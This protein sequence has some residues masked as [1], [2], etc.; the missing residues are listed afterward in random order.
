MTH[1]NYSIKQY[2]RVLETL[3]LIK[4][5]SGEAGVILSRKEHVIISPD[6]LTRGVGVFGTNG[7]G[8]TNT[9]ELFAEEAVAAGKNLVFV[10][11][12][13]DQEAED[14]LYTLAKNNGYDFLLWSPS[15]KRHNFNYSLFQNKSAEYVTAMIME[16]ER[17]ANAE[18]TQ[19][20]SLHYKE[21]TKR[22]VQL[23]VSTFIDANLPIDFGQLYA[24]SSQTGITNIVANNK[25]LS[26]VEKERQNAEIISMWKNKEIQTQWNLAR[27]TFKLMANLDPN[28]DRLSWKN[29]RTLEDVIQSKRKTILLFNLDILGNPIDNARVARMFITDLKQNVRTVKNTGRQLMALFD[30]FGS[31]ATMDM[32]TLLEQGR[33]F[34]VNVVL[35]MQTISNLTNI[36]REFASRILGNCNTRIIHRVMEDEGSE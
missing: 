34:G 35:S 25:K 27:N 28:N 17:Y 12:K 24:Q 1:R 3:S 19:S 22:V 2:Q 18:A 21:I 23:I 6:S 4:I 5:D 20:D 7:T 32:A 9:L 26:P 30:E 14:D 10:N 29:G 33:S 13:G 31:F 8:K 11:G 36:S 15:S 16:I